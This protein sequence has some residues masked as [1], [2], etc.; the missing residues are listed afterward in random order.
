MLA[1]GRGR[2]VLV[3]HE[4]VDLYMGTLGSQVMCDNIPLVNRQRQLCRQNPRVMQAIGAGMKDWISEC[5]HQFRNHRWNCT[6]TAREQLF[7]RLLLRSSREV[8]F[9]YA[10]SSAGVVYTL[11]RACSQGDLDSCSCD[12]TKTGSSRDARGSFDWGGAATMWSMP[13]ASARASV[14][15]CWLAMA[16][17]R[18]TGDHLKK[19]YR[20]AVQVNV[21]QDG[22]GFTHTHTHFKRP[23]K[24]D[25]VLCCGSGY[26]TSRVSRTTQCECKFHWCCAVICRDCEE[27]ID[28]NTCKGHT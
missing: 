10:I 23:S 15:T 9:M 24:N 28:L 27:T 8:A 22:T 7:G 2:C 13:C 16:D 12:P 1:D 19:R 11:A 17:F 26:D 14:R 6:A 18:L 21:N 4:S 25:L 3:V 20:G 5:Q